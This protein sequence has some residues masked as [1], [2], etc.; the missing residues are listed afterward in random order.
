MSLTVINENLVIQHTKIAG[1]KTMVISVWKHEEG[2]GKWEENAPT[3]IQSFDQ[4]GKKYF[5]RLGTF[6]VGNTSI[7]TMPYGNERSEMVRMHYN[8]QF[9]EAYDIMHKHCLVP[10]N[11]AYI[12]G[13]IIYED[14]H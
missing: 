12:G 6:G 5:G 2:I 8:L 9:D 13:E 14:V 11:C 3:T 10:D 4:M 7:K 1:S